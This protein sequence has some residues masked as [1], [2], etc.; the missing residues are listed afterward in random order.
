MHTVKIMTI[1]AVILVLIFCASYFTNT[2]LSSHAQSLE[3]KISIVDTN[4]RKGNWD[5]AEAGLSAIEEEWPK[6]ENIWAVLLDHV[7]IDNID[8]ALEKVSEYVKAKNTPLA[9]A[10]LATLKQYIK[11]IPDKESFNLK[12]I[13]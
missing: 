4:T 11:H 8:E 2:T 9:L 10:E 12:N 1:I 13:F 6:V 7:E 3:E 5:A